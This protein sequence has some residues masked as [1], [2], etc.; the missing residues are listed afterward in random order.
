MEAQWLSANAEAQLKS[1]NLLYI[2]DDKSTLSSL[3]S[4]NFFD[5]MQR[6]FFIFNYFKKKIN[7]LKSP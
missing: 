3:F 6:W 4:P 1:T 7:R 5:F 2:L